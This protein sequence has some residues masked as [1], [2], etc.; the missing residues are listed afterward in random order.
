MTI[1]TNNIKTDWFN[2]GFTIN[3]LIYL[4]ALGAVIRLF[5]SCFTYIINSDGVLYINQAKIIYYGKW[6]MLASSGLDYLAS[7]PFFIAGAYGIFHN[8]MFAAKIVSFLFGVLTLIPIYFL[9]RL[10]FNKPISFL[11]TLLFAFIPIFVDV[12][13]DVM[14]DPIY[15]FFLTNGIYFFIYYLQNIQRDH[16]IYLFLSS[17]AFL[18]AT[19]TRIEAFLF[20]ILPAIYLLITQYK[21][22]DRLLI[23]ILPLVLIAIALTL[24]IKILDIDINI[25]NRTS[26]IADKFTR[27][28]SQYK[29]L[30]SQ[31]STLNDTAVHPSTMLSYFIPKASNCLWLIAL[32][33]LANH[34]FEAIFYPFC[35]ILLIGLSGSFRK[36]K[37]EPKLQFLCLLIVGAWILLY[38]HLIHFW[39]IDARFLAIAVIPSFVFFGFGLEKIFTFFQN[40]FKLKEFTA[41]SIILMLILLSGLAKNMEYRRVDKLVFKQMGE[42]IA[43]KENGNN[44][45]ISILSSS[46]SREMTFYSNYNNKESILQ[47]IIELNFVDVNN[48][49]QFMELVNKF[50]FKYFLWE[51]TFWQQQPFNFINQ[52]Y[53]NNFKELK[54]GYH[55]DTG[56]IILYERL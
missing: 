25:I 53:Q 15:W 35:L 5:T 17:I 2:K 30:R 26:E 12:S 54:R 39:I 49:K 7:Y 56:N 36:I 10:F 47:N 8:W 44:D 1:K 38:V 33:T 14:R 41:F 19:W 20:I 6:E 21:R 3:P 50:H 40:R 28:F 4:F 32:G 34:F 24:N 23:F 18:L 16:K 27:P 52:P 9:F 22:I 51:E 43:E 11:G 48:Y 31:L 42:Y 55:P 37:M 29:L 13:A 46:R 45:Y